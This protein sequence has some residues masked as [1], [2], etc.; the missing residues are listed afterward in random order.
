MSTAP[1]QRSFPAPADS[2]IAALRRLLRPLVRLLLD[3]QVTFPFLAAL[4]K[5][6]Y[7]EVAE[8]EFAIEGRRQT[9]TR[10]SLLTGIH[11]KDVKRLREI[12]PG[13]E[14]PAPSVSLGAQ[15]VGRWLGARPWCDANGRPRPLARHA[16][17]G[18]GASFEELVESVSKDIRPRAVLD[19]WIRLGVARIDDR[20]RVH[21]NVGAFVPEKGF[22][23]KAFFFGRNLRDHIAA[24]VHNLAGGTPSMPDR[25][26]YYD[27][28]SP[29]SVAELQALAEQ[30]GTEALHA[31][32]R[33]ALELQERDAARGQGGQRINFGIYFY[34]G[35]EG[36]ASAREESEE[37]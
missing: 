32:D 20:G 18:E 21:L 24:G 34:R 7:V 6:A 3:H 11:R 10:V 17:A 25:S 5:E 16:G 27:G 12:G 2:L 31:V 9:T 4:L 29:E 35:S 15:L 8:Q 23:E 36:G 14:T 28:L 1:E 30:L 22:D 19:E 33:R 13:E 26:V 37:E